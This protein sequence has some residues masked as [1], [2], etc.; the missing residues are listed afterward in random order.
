MGATSFM[1]ANDVISSVLISNN[2][3]TEVSR[4]QCGNILHE[5]VEL[6]LINQEGELLKISGA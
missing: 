5:V 1:P 4:T 6:L 2:A 3:V